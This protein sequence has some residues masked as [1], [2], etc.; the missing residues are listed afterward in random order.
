[1]ISS[2]PLP[3]LIL[4]VRVP[5]SVHVFRPNVHRTDHV[6]VI[7]TLLQEPVVDS[8]SRACARTVAFS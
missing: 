3:I 4:D 5:D 1:V 7:R 8:G 2:Q 6:A